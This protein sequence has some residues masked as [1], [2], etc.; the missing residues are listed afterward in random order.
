MQVKSIAE[1]RERV[2][3][4]CEEMEVAGI[5]LTTKYCETTADWYY[6]TGELFMSAE[7][8]RQAARIAGLTNKLLERKYRQ[9]AVYDEQAGYRSL[10]DQLDAG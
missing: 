2:L 9:I 6:I 10:L 4:S 8:G 5:E 1:A 3:K 7:W